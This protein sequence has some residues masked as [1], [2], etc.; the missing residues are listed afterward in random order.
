MPGM[1]DIPYDVWILIFQLAC[2]DGGASGCALARTS[3]QFRALSAPVRF[4][5]LTLSSVTQ[6]RHFLVCLE[7][8]RRFDSGRPSGT[9]SRTTLDTLHPAA[10]SDTSPAPIHN[11]LL[12][13]LPDTCDAPQRT[14]RKWTDYARDERSLIFQLA[15]DHKAWAAAKTDWNR[16]F[17]LHVSRL[18][19]L[20]APALHTLAVLQCA[21]VRLPLVPAR[22]PALRELTLLGD[23]RMLLRAPGPGALVSG[24]NDPS[25]FMFYGVPAAAR[26]D[27]DVDPPPFPALTHL[28]VVDTGPKLHPWDKSLPLWPALAPSLTH[29]RV[30]QGTARLPPVLAEMLGVDPAPPFSPSSPLPPPEAEDAGPEDESEA[31]AHAPLRPREA[32][33]PSL[34]VLVVQM[35]GARRNNDEAQRSMLELERIRDECAM[36][37]DGDES[38]DPDPSAT[39]KVRFT[40]LRT[41]AYVPGY[42]EARLRWDWRERMMGGGGC[43]TENEEDEDVWKVFHLERTPGKKGKGREKATV[44]IRELRGDGSSDSQGAGERSARRWWKVVSTRLPRLGRSRLD[45]SSPSHIMERLPTDVWLQIF[46]HACTDGGRTGAALALTSRAVR[47]T[48]A[49]ARFYSLKLSSLAQIGQLLLCIE[50]VERSQLSVQPSPTHTTPFPNTHHLLLSFLPDACDAPKKPWSGHAGY[51]KGT[52]KQRRQLVE[53][54]QAWEEAK[55]AW[56]R[57]FV[58]LV[59]YLFSLVAPTLETLAVLQSPDVRLPYVGTAF[60]VLRE[61]SLL[62]DDQMFVRADPVWSE[63]QGRASFESLRI[64]DQKKSQDGDGGP[65][66]P[67]LTHLHVVY[68]G[69]KAHPWEKTLP[70]WGKLAPSVTHIRVSQASNL[71]PEVLESMTS[72]HRHTPSDPGKRAKV[73]FPKLRRAIVQPFVLEPVRGHEYMEQVKMMSRVKKREGGPDIVVMRGRWYRPGYWQDRLRWEWEGRMLDQPCCWAERE[74]D[75]GEWAFERTKR[76]EL[77][78]LKSKNG[79]AGKHET[80]G[81]VVSGQTI[82][83][84]SRHCH[85]SVVVRAWRSCTDLA[86][87][88]SISA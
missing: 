66:F 67:S 38:A 16:A 23:D 36:G 53:E 3:R 13:F 57:Q 80:I 65:P 43:W 87:K 84:D 59:P 75:E 41:R 2:T 27:A 37:A 83:L 5:S 19:Q 14:F 8:I 63:S 29:L 22:L 42:W 1:R 58:Y 9:A 69:P 45:P 11:L 81:R 39:G 54:Q 44:N 47:A 21:E 51:S 46:P 48:S 52:R 60:P 33:C 64:P 15:H 26:P 86:H 55:A 78:T 62:A 18:L 79:A 25:D 7:R 34:R 17:V 6:V 4:H 50:R 73:A 12:S 76:A 28:H 88:R 32:T 10:G 85:E 77:A 24:Q 74:E 56:D 68:E 71:I 31:G 72:R 70:M 20:A 30:S 49:P 82:R 35:S 61:L 40:I